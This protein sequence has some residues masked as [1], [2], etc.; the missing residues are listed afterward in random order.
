MVLRDM[1]EVKMI[2]FSAPCAPMY[3]FCFTQ[4]T[5]SMEDCRLGAAHKKPTACML[6]PTECISGSETMLLR[7][8]KG[9]AS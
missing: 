7:R 5:R 4:S 6:C 8:A 9:Q 2:V 1:D 3:P